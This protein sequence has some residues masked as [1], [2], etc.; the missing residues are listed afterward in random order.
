MD[1][2]LRPVAFDPWSA[3]PGPS[4]QARYTEAMRTPVLSAGAPPG[5][6][7]AETPG[8]AQAAS[9]AVEL[10]F[11][12]RQEIAHRF[13]TEDALLDAEVTLRTGGADP[14]GSSATRRA[15]LDDLYRIGA[16]VQSDSTATAARVDVDW[17]AIEA[18]MPV[19]DDPLPSP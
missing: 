19:L 16:I 8:F 13:G 18:L 2:E 7:G 10:P 1:G 15:V 6:P 11:S 12:R 17:R 14:F 9:G 3:P 5:W 4:S